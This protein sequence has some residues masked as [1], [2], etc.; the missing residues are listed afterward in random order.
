MTA[1]TNGVAASITHF[2]AAVETAARMMSGML[3]AR[4]QVSV[5]AMMRIEMVIYVAVEV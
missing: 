2:V 3:A 1:A 4:R 5:I